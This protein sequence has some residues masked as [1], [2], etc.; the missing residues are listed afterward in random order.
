LLNV[1]VG[2]NSA[3]AAL[4]ALDTPPDH[5][6]VVIG[7][8]PIGRTVSRLLRDHGIVPTI[9][10]LNLATVRLLRDEGIDAVYGDA[11]HRETLQ[12]A[13][14]DR[15]ATI[16]LSADVTNAEEVIRLARDI[17]PQVH[18]LARTSYLHDVDRVRRAGADHVFASEGELALTLTEAV[19]Q[20]IRATPEEIDRARRRIHAELFE[21]ME[22]YEIRGRQKP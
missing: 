16:I 7:Y 6:A 9:I 17:N 2:S 22:S 12:Q 15:A 21:E 3:D 13:G 11:G 10:D 14:V 1:A 8:G 4:R 18:V 19:L 5:R 20:Q